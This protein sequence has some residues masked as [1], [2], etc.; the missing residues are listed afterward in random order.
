MVLGNTF[1]YLMSI[2]N[3]MLQQKAGSAL[4]GATFNFM[5]P[6]LLAS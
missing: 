1:I 2:E 6:E 5:V 3:I 4:V